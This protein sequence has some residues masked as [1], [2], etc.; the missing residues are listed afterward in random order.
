LT[1]NQDVFIL[2]AVRF[3]LHDFKLENTIVS[4]SNVHQMFGLSKEKRPWS[5][6]PPA[7]RILQSDCT[8]GFWW[9]HDHAAL[10]FWDSSRANFR[11]QTQFMKLLAQSTNIKEA[12][13]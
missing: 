7:P 4:H 1:F 6:Q 2:A 13:N 10:P 12:E 3:P 8:T 11:T 9:D 5:K